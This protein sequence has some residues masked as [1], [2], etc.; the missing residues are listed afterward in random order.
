MTNL[1]IGAT[2]MYNSCH[3][4]V[5]LQIIY[6]NLRKGIQNRFICPSTANFMIV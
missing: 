3:N 2:V 5:Y 1:K 6:P 4:G